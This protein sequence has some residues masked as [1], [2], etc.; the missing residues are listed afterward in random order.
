MKTDKIK[1]EK[2]QSDKVDYLTYYDSVFV[3]FIDKEINLL[4]LGIFK[5]GSLLMWRDY[6]ENG[7]ISGLDLKVPDGFDNLEKIKVFQ[8]RQED[9]DFL[10]LVAKISA[11]DG[12]DII[13]DDAS[14]FGHLTKISFWHLFRN[15]LKSGGVYAIEDWGTGYWDEWP[16][17]KSLNLDVQEMDKDTRITKE[18]FQCHSYG[19]VGLVKQLIDEQG[20]LDITKYTDNSRKSLFESIIITPHIVFVKKA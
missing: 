12:F 2:Y 16:D 5:G 10:S 8:G 17:G 11:P 4:E 19:M 15:H 3:E 6:F 1:F 20:A 9:V 14:H 13:I 7:T 18:P